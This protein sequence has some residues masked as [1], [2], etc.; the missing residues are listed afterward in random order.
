M[1]LRKQS[2]VLSSNK[3]V[4]YELKLCSKVEKFSARGFKFNDRVV[5][6]DKKEI[7]YYSKVPKHFKR[8][9]FKLLRNT[10]KMGVPT[11]LCEIQ[12][13]HEE[14]LTKKK[15]S[16]VLKL[17]FPHG[18]QMLYKIENNELTRRN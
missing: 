2:N 7:R 9:E 17:V 14:W 16:N 12:Y 11:C 1:D 15:K 18:S 8:N 3:P 10:P 6:I 5:Y 13:P 4:S